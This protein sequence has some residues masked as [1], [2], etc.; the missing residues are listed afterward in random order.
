MSDEQQ[1]P[2]TRTEVPAPGGTTEGA[3][4]PEPSLDAVQAELEAMRRQA[5]EYLSLL[6]RVQA[7]FINYKRRIEQERVEQ[8]RDLKAEVIRAILPVVDDFAR[9]VAA[10]PLDLA[11]NEWAGG[12]AL[13]LRKL[14]TTLEAQG[15]ARIDALGKD[16][17]PWLHEAVASEDAGPEQSGKVIAVLRDGYALDGKVV[18]PAQVKVGR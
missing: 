6:Q 13:V 4:A 11:E 5:Q 10:R 17:D 2:P 3:A 15:M 7:D 18:R 8:R 12:V 16:F 14:W 9:A 1:T